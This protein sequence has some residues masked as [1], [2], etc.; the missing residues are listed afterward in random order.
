MRVRPLTSF[1]QDLAT[2]GWQ[3]GS[4]VLGISQLPASDD[5][6]EH[7]KVP[8]GRTIMRVERLRTVQGE[9]IAHEVAL[10]PRV[11][12]DLAERLNEHGSLYRALRD[13]Y[14]VTVATA[15]D[16]VETAL[17]DPVTADLLGVE[18]GLPILLIHRIGWDVDGHPVEWSVSRF[19]GDRFRFVSHQKLH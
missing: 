1:S 7:L 6:S 2:E 15:E 11:L 12:P 9:P 16:T 5:A 18:T 3:P 17:A 8:P 13:A 4:V 19:R 10:L 14:G